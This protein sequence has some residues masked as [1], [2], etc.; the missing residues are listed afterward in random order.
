MF[1]TWTAS[2]EDAESLAREVE[3][4]LNEFAERVISVGYAVAEGRHHAMV[5]YE[6]VAPSEDG[7][8]EAAVSIAEDIVER[9]QA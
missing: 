2:D 3:G 6:A 4:H 8:M 7:H 5:V 1:K 9:A